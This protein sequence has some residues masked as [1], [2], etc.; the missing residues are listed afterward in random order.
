[1]F[2]R[3]L[4]VLIKRRGERVEEPA[5]GAR[6]GVGANASLFEHLLRELRRGRAL[7]H[8]D[9]RG[10]SPGL[11][12]TVL[13][14]ANNLAAH[15]ELVGGRRVAALGVAP[16]DRVAGLEHV[17]ARTNR[18][19][20]A[21]D[22]ELPVRSGLRIIAKRLAR[23]DGRGDGIEVPAPGSHAVIGGEAVLLE[24]RLRE[25]G[26]VDPVF[27][28]YGSAAVQVCWLPS[29]SMPITEHVAVTSG[30]T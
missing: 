17:A 8:L 19:G 29:A 14:L 5:V 7:L 12:A 30:A 23:V 26:G 4:Y 25:V 6:P 10:L 27:N 9:S 3:E 18:C 11:L 20:R 21:V 22:E 28:V 15:G 1:M 13:S 24:E 16:D 2:G